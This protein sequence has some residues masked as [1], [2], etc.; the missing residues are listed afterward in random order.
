LY[1]II[2]VNNNIIIYY[3]YYNEIGVYIKL[4]KN[5]NLWNYIQLK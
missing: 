1:I 2:I 4:K 3:Y 5:K